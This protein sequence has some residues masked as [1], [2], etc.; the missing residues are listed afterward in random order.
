MEL[1]KVQKRATKM[2]TG[3]GHLSYEERLQHLELFSLE[4]RLLRG[5]ITEMYNIMQGVD[6]VDRGKL[7]SLS[8]NTRTRRHPL[9]LNVGRMRIDKR[10]HFFTQCVV[11]L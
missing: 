6:K 5:D 7:C 4:K 8:C 11:S 1:E 9:K 10:K 2:M 3:L